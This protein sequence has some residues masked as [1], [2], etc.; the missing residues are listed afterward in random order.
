MLMQV[1]IYYLP[2]TDTTS[3]YTEYIQTELIKSLSAE[4]CYHFEMKYSLA[5]ISTSAP[6]RLQALFSSTQFTTA[7]YQYDNNLN[8]QIQLDSNT[9]ITD[10]LNWLKLSGSFK[11]S[12]GEKYLT[13][14][15]F[16]DKEHTKRLNLS[17][18]FS[19]PCAVASSSSAYIYIDDIVLYEIPK[20]NL[21]TDTIFCLGDDSLAIGDS[22]LPGNNLIWYKDGFLLSNN[23][24]TIKIKPTN[25]GIY[26]LTN[27]SCASDTI[28][29]SILDCYE[30][31]STDLIIPNTFTPNGDNINDTFKIELKGGGDVLFSVYNRWG[32]LVHQSND[33]TS[34]TTVMWD[35]RTTSGEP[36]S[37]GVYFY[38]LSY[39]DAN[40]EPQSLKGYVSLF[41]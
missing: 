6:N 33:K 15:N 18:T 13:I 12:G 41:R 22:T 21:G 17:S 32:N 28:L 29:I 35:G 30:T 39:T 38:T 2:V 1:Y 19:S 34:Q 7:L 26:T 20:P 8:T 23:T 40:G 36:C 27:E 10:T 9:Y 37:E 3:I 24:N 5:N 16:K 11:A 31:I 25:S 14:G 4:T